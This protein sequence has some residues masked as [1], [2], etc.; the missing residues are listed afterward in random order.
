MNWEMSADIGDLN[1]KSDTYGEWE[2][3]GR[4]VAFME[5]THNDCIIY[6]GDMAA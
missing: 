5:V 3:L 1:L 6:D 4:K 2:A